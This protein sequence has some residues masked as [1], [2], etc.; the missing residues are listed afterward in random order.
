MDTYNKAKSAVY[1]LIRTDDENGVAA[2]ICDGAIITLIAVNVLLVILDTFGFAPAVQ[3]AFRQIEIVS[4]AVFTVEYAARL[5]TADKITPSLSP[6][7]ARLKYAVSFMAVS[8]LLAIL[9]FYLPFVIP[10][11]LRILRLL[12]LLKVNRYT[13]ALSTVGAVMRRKASQLISSMLVV[14]A[15]MVI[16][17]VL[18]YNV[19]NDAQPEVFQNAFSGLWWAIATLTTVGYGDIYPITAAGKILSAV[20]ALLGI[21][22]VAVPT[23]IISSGFVEHIGAEKAEPDDE[24]SYCPYCGKTLK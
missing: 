8:D 5:W 12:R 1:N 17:S 6:L 14:L 9:P 3:A 18:M 11:D 21:G 23:G 16:A 2:S 20:I 15:V 22:L 13:S 24:K 10:V 7:A 4:V 19:E